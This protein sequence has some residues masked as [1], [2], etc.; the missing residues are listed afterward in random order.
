MEDKVYKTYYFLP[1]ELA[2]Y[3]TGADVKIERG[4]KEEPTQVY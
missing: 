2:W 4:G 1:S 3:F